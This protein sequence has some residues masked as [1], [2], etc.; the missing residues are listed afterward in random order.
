METVKWFRIRRNLQWGHGVGNA[1][2]SLSACTPPQGCMFL[3]S[4]PKGA[5]GVFEF[6]CHTYIGLLGKVI[7]E[8]GN[9]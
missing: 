5:R 9:R 3:A 7:L 2:K 1:Q 6:E 8:E 4:T